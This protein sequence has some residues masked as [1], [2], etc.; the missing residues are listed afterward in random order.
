MARRFINNKE[1][2]KE[3]V[4]GHSWVSTYK[5]QREHLKAEVGHA[6]RG[7]WP[8]RTGMQKF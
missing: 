8:W 4:T 1:K 7:K 3:Q 5:E 2:R 6:T